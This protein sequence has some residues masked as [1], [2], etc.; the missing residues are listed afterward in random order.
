MLLRFFPPILDR[1]VRDPVLRSPRPHRAELGEQMLERSE[2][3]GELLTCHP[4]IPQTEEFAERSNIGHSKVEAALDQLVLAALAFAA[5]ARVLLR[6]EFVRLT[7]GLILDHKF[8]AGDATGGPGEVLDRARNLEDDHT[9][10][11]EC[12]RIGAQLEGTLGPR[13]SASLSLP[14][15]GPIRFD[16]VALVGTIGFMP[17]PGNR[18]GPMPSGFGRISR[19]RS[20]IYHASLAGLACSR[21]RIPDVQLLGHDRFDRLFS[22]RKHAAPLNVETELLGL[23]VTNPAEASRDDSRRVTERLGEAFRKCL[24]V[25]RERAGIRKR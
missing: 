25:T 21:S 8:E 17:P 10:G 18:G 19:G 24:D 3:R 11:R 15:E 6:E 12:G 23:G 5:R 7:L 2:A 16:C 9:V 22:D 20:A 4:A 13:A 1:F 14:R